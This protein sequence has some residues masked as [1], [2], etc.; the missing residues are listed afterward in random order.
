MVLVARLYPYIGGYA[1]YLSNDRPLDPLRLI[2][3]ARRLLWVALFISFMVVMGYFHV[4]ITYT[5]LGSVF[6]CVVPQLF[7][8]KREIPETN[9]INYTMYFG[10]CESRA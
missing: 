3:W 2:K 8:K 7:K 1:V 6:C 9:Q 5:F 10:Y 4:I